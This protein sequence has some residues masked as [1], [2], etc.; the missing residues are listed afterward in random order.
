[1]DTSMLAS[2]RRSLHA[3]AELVMAGPQY[4]QS[5]TIRL[6]VVASGVRTRK[7]PLLQV[8]GAEM[9][10]ADGRLSL[11]DTTCARLG[12]AIGVDV[13]PPIGLYHDGSGFRPDDVVDVDADS[14]QWLIGCLWTG[15]Q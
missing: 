5:G 9:V 11:R 3:V 10:A 12:A 8:E 15:Q 7:P 13:G 14:A 4:R 6:Q 1:M 2:T